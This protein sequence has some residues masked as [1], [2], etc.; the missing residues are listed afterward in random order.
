MERMPDTQVSLYHFPIQVSF[1]HV[2]P[3]DRVAAAARDKARRL[4][5]V[6]GGIMRCEV[7]IE[8]SSRRPTKGWLYHVRVH[9]AVPGCEIVVGRDPAKA[10]AHGD[11][12]VALRDAFDATRRQLQSYGRRRR[13]DAGRRR[14]YK[15]VA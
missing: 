6:A 11:V 8:A 13:G 15:Q 4:C 1:R 3:N 2:P 7:M 14:T 5:R 10:A 9:V 12:Y